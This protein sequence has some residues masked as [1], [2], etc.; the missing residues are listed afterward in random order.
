MRPRPQLDKT[1]TP[2]DFTRRKALNLVVGY[3]AAMSFFATEG[4]TCSDYKVVT[5]NHVTMEAKTLTSA[6]IIGKYSLTD[7]EYN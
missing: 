4:M 6:P 7:V 1:K 5:H 3:A 2:L